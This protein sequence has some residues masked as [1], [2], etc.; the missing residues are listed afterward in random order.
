MRFFRNAVCGKNRILTS[1]EGRMRPLQNAGV[2]QMRFSRI[3]SEIFRFEN[4]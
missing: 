2:P 3:F 1:G 4:N